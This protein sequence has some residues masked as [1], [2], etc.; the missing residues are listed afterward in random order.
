MKKTKT[1]FIISICLILT[2]C[3]IF[4]GVMSSLSWDFTKLSTTKAEI[5]EY[6]IKEEYKSISILTDTADVLFVASGEERTVIECTEEEK[7]KH[8]VE[9]KDGTL[10]IKKDDSRKW[11][12]KIGINFTS[13]KITVKIPAGEFLCLLVETSTGKVEI[14]NDFKFKSIDISASTGNILVKACAQE[15]I[16]IKTSTGDV[17]VKDVQ[18]KAIDA[19]AT[20]GKITLLNVHCENDINLK[21]TTGRTELKNVTGKNLSS[22]G[23]TGRIDLTNTVLKESILINRS[24]GDVSFSA[25]DAGEMAINTSTGS[26]KG[27]LLSEKDFITKTNTGNV[28]V[29][30]T[31]S[32]GK[33][34]IATDT[35][36]IKIEIQ[37]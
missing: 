21:V 32:G 11:Y 30:K 14:P 16:K 6:E 19:S 35:G 1:W 2:G 9:V 12:Q 7:N 5:N 3:V 13:P 18:A 33:C 8:I 24:T 37:K 31:I 20:T 36:N 4:M 23:S 22:G 15:S 26:V 28:D 34:E 29:P 25:C 17:L 10:Y 27:S